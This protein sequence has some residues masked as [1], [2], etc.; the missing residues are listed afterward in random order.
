[1]PEP[2]NQVAEEGGRYQI[3][4]VDA[5]LVCELWFAPGVWGSNTKLDLSPVLPGGSGLR[6][7]RGV[8]HGG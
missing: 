1:M 7:G 8:I 5:R 4:A 3:G 6:N 2:T